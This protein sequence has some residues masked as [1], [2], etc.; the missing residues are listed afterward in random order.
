M[1]A[2]GTAYAGPYNGSVNTAGM[3]IGPGVAPQADIYALRV[4]GCAGARPSRR[5]R[6]SGPP[7][8]TGTATRP[9]TST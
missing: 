4:F 3:G 9:T 6:S 8:R 5:R 7:T 1:N 2:D